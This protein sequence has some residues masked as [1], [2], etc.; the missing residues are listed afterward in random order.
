[1]TIKLVLVCLTWLSTC[2]PGIAVPNQLWSHWRSAEHSYSIQQ[3]T[4]D[5]ASPL[6][7][8]LH[9]MWRTMAFKVRWDCDVSKPNPTSHDP[10]PEVIHPTYDSAQHV[11][12]SSADLQ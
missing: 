2:P 6:S 11:Q 7:E 10:R 9:I 3:D 1:M 8:R 4:E 5:E 12:A